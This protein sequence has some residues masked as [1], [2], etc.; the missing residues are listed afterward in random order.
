M[1]P[2]LY[3]YILL[4]LFV[5]L[6]VW[7]LFPYAV[8][9]FQARQLAGLCRKHRVVVLSFDDGPSE[10]LT[11][12]VVALLRQLGIR[13]SFFLIGERALQNPLVVRQITAEGH[14]LGSHTACHLNAWK[15]GPRA[16]CRDMLNGHRQIVALVGETQ[17]FRPPYGKMSF[18]SFILAKMN[19]LSLAWWTIDARD[20]LE[21]PR[22]HDD[23]L[24]RITA[25]RGGVVL[26]H[27]YD[28]FP[29]PDHGGY[30]LGLIEKIA[31]LASA[32]GLRFATFS[33]LSGLASSPVGAEMAHSSARL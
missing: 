19:G 31:V 28:S 21:Q 9:R 10:S 5:V 24:A 8:R 20:S 26:L 6:G 4:G 14:E 25:A 17:L 3:P 7:F 15:S 32:E 11:P 12:R 2:L 16:H 30:V 13:A 33:E 23:V 18:A 29:N 27:D 22:S 1:V